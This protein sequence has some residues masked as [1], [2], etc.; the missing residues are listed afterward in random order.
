MVAAGGADG[1]PAVT[2]G[3]DAAVDAAGSDA[4][5]TRSADASDEQRLGQIGEACQTSRDCATGLGCVPSS[6]GASVCDLL[7]YGL[8]PNGKTCSGECSAASDCCAL[9]PGLGLSAIDDAGFYVSVADC[10]D[11]L[12]AMIGGDISACARGPAPGT[13]VA[14]G[15]FYH[16]TYC[17]CPANTWSC[18]SVGRCAYTASCT[19]TMA[20]TLGGC[21]LITRTGTT[22]NTACDLPAGKCH[23]G[24]SGCTTDTDCNGL[25]VSDEV[26]ITCRA[27]DCTCYMSA[28]YLKCTKDLDCQN[29]KSCDMMKSLCVPAPCTTDAQCFSQLGKARAQ[30]KSGV[31]GIPC[32]VDGD[33]SP[34]G[35][36]S[37]QPFNGTVCG[38]NGVCAPVGCTTDADCSGVGST[39]LFCASPQVAAVH[40]AITN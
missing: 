20:N 23:S 40:S 4:G 2:P 12:T 27:G 39:R 24:L 13:S 29:G 16:Q 14:T 5:V 31:C 9:P 18:S 30:C 26:G 36:L 35:D 1:A 28:C 32:T 15:C 22:L 21:P 8:M 38:P 3:V 10:Q 34:S 33:C 6:G 25:A 11:I 17:S 37:G 7:S 19:G